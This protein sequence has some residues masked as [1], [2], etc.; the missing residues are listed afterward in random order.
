[1]AEE[2][3]SLGLNDVS[4]NPLLRSEWR[5]LTTR[6]GNP[7]TLRS[8]LFSWNGLPRRFKITP[9][10]RVIP[11]NMKTSLVLD[12]RA[13][14]KLGLGI[15]IGSLLGLA[16]ARAEDRTSNRQTPGS[17]GNMGPRTD[18]GLTLPRWSMPVSRAKLLRMSG[19]YQ[20][21]GFSWSRIS[22]SWWAKKLPW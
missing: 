17:N 12:R 14:L 20:T 4:C 19:S 8:S 18:P 15:G 6:N 10:G 13:A 9:F 5:G 7:N 21:A 11:T 16:S 22:E 3:K 1:L 2:G